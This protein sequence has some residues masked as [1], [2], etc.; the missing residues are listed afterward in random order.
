MKAKKYLFFTIAVAALAVVFNLQNKAEADA[1]KS[2]LKFQTGKALIID[3][4]EK[5]EV[6]EGMIKGAIW[7][8]LSRIESDSLK[9][10]EH[11]KKLTE[12]KELYLYCRSGNRSGKVQTILKQAGIEA[13][14]LGS[15]SELIKQQLPTQPGIE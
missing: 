9:E 2:Y 6:K 3:V 7:I 11:L 5:V 8:P 14:N 13:Y 12:G 4:R 15:F 1:K 10:I